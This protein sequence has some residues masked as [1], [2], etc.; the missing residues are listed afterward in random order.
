MTTHTL[1]YQDTV[2]TSND[3]LPLFHI[4]CG[5]CGLDDPDTQRQMM[6]HYKLME[7]KVAVYSE[8]VGLVEI[9]TN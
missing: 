3:L 8:T 6:E 5:L 4:L 2:V 1:T 7:G 9:V